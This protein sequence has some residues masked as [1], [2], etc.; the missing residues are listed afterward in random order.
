[1]PLGSMTQDRAWNEE[2]WL[3]LT[4]LAQSVQSFQS[5]FA[6]HWCDPVK[7]RRQPVV[8]ELESTRFWLVRKT[9]HLKNLRRRLMPN[10]IVCAFFFECNAGLTS[11]LLSVA[12][13]GMRQMSSINSRDRV[14]EGRRN[15][16]TKTW[17]TNFLRSQKAHA[18]GRL[19]FGFRAPGRPK[20]LEAAKLLDWVTES[21]RTRGVK[22]RRAIPSVKIHKNTSNRLNNGK[23]E[24]QRCG[25][26]KE[27]TRG[28][29]GPRKKWLRSK[30]QMISKCLSVTGKLCHL[31]Y[32]APPQILRRI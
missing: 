4:N 17:H 20:R 31:R 19:V 24:N 18:Y 23:I 1:M 26:G 21:I 11:R 7:N 5:A 13:L 10:T 32:R 15:L 28:D 27:N 2:C 25:K 30:I 22:A 8:Y 29:D 9:M 6:A 16:K 14:R 3:P 12:F